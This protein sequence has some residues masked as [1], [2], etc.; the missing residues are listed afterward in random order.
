VT[1]RRVA[2]VG[3]GGILPNTPYRCVQGEWKK[4]EV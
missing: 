1:E 3:Q 4:V 2:M